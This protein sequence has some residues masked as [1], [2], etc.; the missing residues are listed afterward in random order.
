MPCDQAIEMTVNKLRKPT[1]DYQES[2][3]TTVLESAG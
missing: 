2:Q 1:N 3:K